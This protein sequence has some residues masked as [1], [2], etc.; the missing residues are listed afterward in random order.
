MHNDI[1]IP[2]YTSGNSLLSLWPGVAVGVAL[3]YT[4]NG[5]S[6]AIIMITVYCLYL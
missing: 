4:I 5:M 1:P 2:M 3:W 6:T